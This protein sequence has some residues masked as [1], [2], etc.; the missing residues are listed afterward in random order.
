M[1]GDVHVRFCERPGVRFPRATH[2]VVMCHRRLQAEEARRNLE[3]MLGRLGLELHPEKTRLV[4]LSW[5][6]EG[7][8]FLGCTIR[9]RRSIQRNPRRYYMQRWPSP[10]AMRKIRSRVHELT[11]ARW[12]GIRD[13]GEVIQYLSLVLCGWGNYFRSGNANR[14]F[15]Q[16]DDYVYER[17]HRWLWRRGGQRPRVR[18]ERWP[19]DRLFGLGLHKLR[20]SVCYP[21]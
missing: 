11:D 16:I 14:K 18:W 2:L 7:F 5:G 1:S 13:I 8:E 4:D 12:N 17:L 19:R 20:G 15:A 21:A 10:K 6:K 9:K 3:V